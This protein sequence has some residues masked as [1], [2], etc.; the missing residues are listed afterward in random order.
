[1]QVLGCCCCRCAHMHATAVPMASHAQMCVQTAILQL[2][3]HAC[4]LPG[5]AAA[6]NK[7]SPG[8]DSDIQPA[9][10]AKVVSTLRAALDDESAAVICAAAPALL[11]V[12]RTE[13]AAA[14]WSWASLCPN[15]GQP[16]MHGQ[17][18]LSAPCVLADLDASDLHTHALGRLV[19]WS[20]PACKGRPQVKPVSHACGP[21]MPHCSLEWLHAFALS[22]CQP[23]H[24]CQQD[25]PELHTKD[26]LSR[27]PPLKHGRL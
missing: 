14:T 16:A 24:R 11:T 20:S 8:Q 18:Q 12:V 15:T 1:M 2:C 3:R 4:H 23:G 22:S 19:L 17:H 7:R 21:C 10:Q 25:C 5:S 27:C 6:A 13:H 26:A 9:E